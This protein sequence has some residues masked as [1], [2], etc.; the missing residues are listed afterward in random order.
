MAHEICIQGGKVH[1]MYVDEEPWHG[2]GTRLE[3][4]ATSAQAMAAAHLDWR[5]KKVPLYAAEFG[6]RMEVPKANALVRS[7][8]WDDE[9]H[10]CP[11]FGIVSDAYTP[12]QNR[13]AFVFLDSI[14]GEGA[15]VYHTAGALGNGERVWMLVKLP[16]H[17]TVIGDDIADK[18][19][20]LAN[21]H[22]GEGSVQVKFTPIRVVCNNTLTLALKGGSLIRV[23]HFHNARERLEEAKEKLGIID[24]RFDEIGEAFR[25]MLKVQMDRQG[26][27]DYLGAVF[28]M[29][30]KATPKQKER[31][32]SDRALAEHLFSEGEG[33]K[34]RGV[35]GTLWAA[36]NGVTELIDHREMPNLSA[37]RRLASVWFGAG[38]AVKARA[39]GYAVDLTQGRELLAGGTS[40]AAPLGDSGKRRGFFGWRRGQDN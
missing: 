9:N 30:E 2:L 38:A 33:D 14:V 5:V 31:I 36:F 1:M 15:A 24:Q 13:D 29:P 35:N 32:N 25:A 11:I 23:R 21:D 16:G 39:Y 22:R 26:L 8:L 4:P 3:R 28:P 7:D 10:E 34:A 6:R 27:H 37:E 40:E 17:L 12:V 18:Y 19:L 20:L